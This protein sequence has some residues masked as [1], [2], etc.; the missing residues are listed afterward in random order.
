MRR[1]NLK[2]NESA[3]IKS[4]KKTNIDKRKLVSFIISCITILISIGIIITMLVIGV[5]PFKYMIALILGLL[6]INSA[7]CFTLLKKRK[8]KKIR[9]IINILQVILAVIELI[10][11]IY[12]LKT[13]ILIDSMNDNANTKKQ[14]Y[15][16]IV[17][18]DSEYNEIEDLEGKVIE[19]YS[20]DLDN[21]ELALEKLKETVDVNAVSNEDIALVGKTLLNS[22]V[23]AILLEDSQKTLLGEELEGFDDKTK[24]IYTFSIDVEVET[25]AKDTEVTS[26]TFIV[27]I[28]GI[29]TYGTISSVSRSD[30]NI[31]AVINPKTYQVL[32]VNI[33][34]DYYVQLHGTTGKRDKL[35]HAG[36][37]GVE[38]SVQTIEDLLDIDINYYF[39]VN[40]T[41]LVDIVDAIG[42]IEVYSEY[43]FTSYIDNYNFKKGYNSM[44][45]KQA[46]AFARERKAFATGDRMRGKNQ[47]AVIN[48][49]IKKASKPS[50]ITKF[51]SLLKSLS[52]KF[53]TNM[54]TG[55]MMELA[56]LQ[57][58]KMPTWNVS[59]ISLT[60]GDGRAS[61]YS[62]GSQL[63]YVM[64][65]SQD[66]IDDAKQKINAVIAGEILE[67]SYEEVTGN[68]YKPTQAEANATPIV[69]EE[70][71]EEPEEPVKEE[72]VDENNSDENNNNND[73]NENTDPDD[74]KE[75]PGVVD[76][77]DPNS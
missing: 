57:I 16:V 59:T 26:E 55:K 37:Y 4:T 70:P 68:I 33:P 1:K 69:K 62:T 2:T 20:N 28:S 75:D 44:N 74:G 72:P 23:D 61:T 51:D 19:Y 32:L 40:F 56:R 67:A 76:P 41:S 13:Y 46:L 22:E 42:G 9:N 7:F 12:V 30:V 5:L 77:Y 47:Q 18:K 31:V 60:G 24:V 48:G 39:K 73:N 65:P 34:R 21:S 8:S 27:Y 35:T 45:G 15:S 49:I 63:L 17:L 43:S 66:S 25:I 50:I 54:D 38:K 10:I 29:D 6:I 3:E 58:S 64:Y 14:N 11:G 52:N 36:M 71:K 53:Q